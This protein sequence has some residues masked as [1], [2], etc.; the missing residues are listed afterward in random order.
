MALLDR[1]PAIRKLDSDRSDLLAIEIAGEVNGADVENLCGLLDA[2]YAMHPQIDL[3][4]VWSSDEP[5][6][7]AEVSEET[8]GELRDGARAHVRRCAAVGGS[9]DVSR[10]LHSAG[11]TSRTEFRRFSIDE[12]EEAWTWIGG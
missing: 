9:G 1:M 10:L 7:W 5:V 11:D 8:L 6:D 2:A 12:T 3:F 4:V